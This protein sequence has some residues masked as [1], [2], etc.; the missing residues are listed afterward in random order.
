MQ[1]AHQT[2]T[3]VFPEKQAQLLKLSQKDPAFAR[4]A[5]SYEALEQRIS[6]IEAGAETADASALDALRQERAALKDDIA[7][8][9]K[10]ASGSCCG[11]CGG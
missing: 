11:G 9:L 7:R 3:N 6:G 10:H 1:L 8:D 2:L 5:E 4:K